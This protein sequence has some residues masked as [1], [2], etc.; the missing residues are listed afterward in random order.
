MSGTRVARRQQSG[1]FCAGIVRLVD[2]DLID[3]FYQTR[4]LLDTFG[5]D[6]NLAPNKEEYQR[7]EE[8]IDRPDYFHDF[9]ED[10]RQ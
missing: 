7:E 1:G 10:F 8:E 2:P 4:G 9:H 3:F 5:N 6:V